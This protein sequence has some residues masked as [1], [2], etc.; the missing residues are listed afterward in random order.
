LERCNLS[1]LVAVLMTDH[2]PGGFCDGG[3]NGTQASIYASQART[4]CIKINAIQVNDYSDA[5]SIMTN[6]Q[7]TTCGWYQQIPSDGTGIVDAILRMFREP[8][9]CVCP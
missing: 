5:T 1:L 7:Q 3:D 9:Y 8:G 2:E 6:Y 4:N